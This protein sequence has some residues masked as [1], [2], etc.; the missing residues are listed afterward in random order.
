[1]LLAYEPMNILAYALQKYKNPERTT[2]R[3][4]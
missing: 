1:M 4:S 3:G 2:E